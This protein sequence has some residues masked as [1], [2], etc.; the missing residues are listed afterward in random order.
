MATE[1]SLLVV[2]GKGVALSAD[3]PTPVASFRTVSPN[4]VRIVNR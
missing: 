3:R 2:S 4:E 1:T